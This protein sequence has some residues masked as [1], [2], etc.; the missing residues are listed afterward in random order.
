M[1]LSQTVK[2]L[3]RVTVRPYL[4][5]RGFEGT[6]PRFERTV[7]ETPQRIE[8]QRA[9]F[10]YMKGFVYLNGIISVPV[11]DQLLGRTVRRNIT[12][13]PNHVDR[14]LD[15]AIIV[16]HTSD[17]DDLSAV[18]VRGL[19]AL[20]SRMNELTT[21][22]DA[23]DYLSAKKLNDF[24]GVFGWYLQHDQLDR[25]Q[26]FITGLHEYFGAQ[27]RW[28]KLAGK[29]DDVAAHVAPDTAWR[30]WLSNS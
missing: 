7:G 16:T 15:E 25:A 23:V 3:E 30:T 12:L 6:G 24:E 4:R 18:A 20:A 5:E 13:R 11:L 1:K 29:L 14:N 10:D 26:T 19:D 9:K 2:D 28:E 27:P 17:P 22:A 8:V 21:T